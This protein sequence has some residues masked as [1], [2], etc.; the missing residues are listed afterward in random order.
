[1]FY[2]QTVLVFLF[3]AICVCII[4]DTIYDYVKTK[5]LIASN[6]YTYEESFDELYFKK[7]SKSFFK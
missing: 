3:A 2:I 4:V 5:S 1:M 6:T 7:F